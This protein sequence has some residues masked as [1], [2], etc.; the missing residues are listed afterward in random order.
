MGEDAAVRDDVV[1][2]IKKSTSGIVE[3]SAGVGRSRR[4]GTLDGTLLRW[5]GRTETVAVRE[6]VE[7]EEET[8]ETEEAAAAQVLGTFLKEGF[9]LSLGVDGVAWT[10]V[11]DDMGGIVFLV[12]VVYVFY[13]GGDDVLCSGVVLWEE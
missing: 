6:D 1:V 4:V 2:E 3:M 5:G 12:A 11:L 7:E 13:G 8:E 10:S 9:F